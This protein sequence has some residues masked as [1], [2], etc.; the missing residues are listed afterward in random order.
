MD[1]NLLERARALTASTPTKAL[2]AGSSAI[3]IAR[4][5]VETPKSGLDVYFAIDTT[6]SMEPYVNQAREN[7]Q[8]VTNELLNGSSDIRISINGVG[9][10]CDGDNCLQLYAPTSNPAQVHGAIESLV[11][12]NGGDEPEA[13]ECLALALTQYIPTDSKNRRR[14]VVLVGDSVPHGMLDKPCINGVDYQRAFEGLKVLC[15]GFYIVGCNPQMYSHQR[16]LINPNREEE[17]LISLGDMASLLPSL[18]V[19]LAKKTES[20]SALE[21]YMKQLT[22]NVSEKIRGLLNGK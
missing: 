14:A 15:N 5:Y 7:I 22:P 13:Y 18:L 12:T 21:A 20:A 4:K 9:D 10:H 16:K 1:K 3:E 17:K 2:P 11:M 19:A 6:G 8:M